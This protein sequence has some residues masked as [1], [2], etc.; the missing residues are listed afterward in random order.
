MYL[1]AARTAPVHR[2]DLDHFAV[3]GRRF[4]HPAAFPD[5]VRC[6]LLDV[7]V[8][9]GLQRPDGGERVP[10]VRRRDHDG[11]D[12]LVVEHPPEILN[13]PGLERRHVR[14][15][16]VVDPRRFE[17]RVDVAQR[18]DLH[19]RQPREP[20]LQRVALTPDAD[21]GGDDPVVRAE[22]AA[23]HAASLGRDP[24]ELPANRETRGGRA[25]SRSEIP[26]RQ[27]VLIFLIG[28]HGPSSYSGG[29]RPSG[30]PYAFA[31][32]APGPRSALASAPLARCFRSRSY[33]L[34]ASALR[35]TASQALQL[36]DEGS[37]R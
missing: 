24:E 33:H 27:A 29:L 9:A 23:P 8:L 16:L 25:D 20:L 5:R 7:D 34:A 35:A 13:E 18:L 11:V 15:F 12:V 32:G 17:V 28:G 1:I 31:R 2:A 4:D 6:G 3:A 22:H 37:R 36:K 14:Q 10:V 21:A 19:I 30:P 26:A